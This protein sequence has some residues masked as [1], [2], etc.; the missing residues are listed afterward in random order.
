M[1]SGLLWID[2]DVREGVDHCVRHGKPVEAEEEVLHVLKVHH[3]RVV[4]SV[5]EVGLVG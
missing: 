2:E 1:L 3:L 5:E 4:A